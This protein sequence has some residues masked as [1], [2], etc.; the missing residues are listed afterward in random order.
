MLDLIFYLV[1]QTIKCAVVHVQAV[2]CNLPHI[3]SC[4]KMCFLSADALSFDCKNP[5][6]FILL[7]IIKIKGKVPDLDMHGSVFYT[8]IKDSF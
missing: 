2:S 6:V 3:T 4:L 7:C 8:F 1:R 5:S